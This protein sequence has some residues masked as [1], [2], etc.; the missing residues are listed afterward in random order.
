M[1]FSGM[2]SS[3]P[4]TP[5]RGG[6]HF[7]SCCSVTVLPADSKWQREGVDDEADRSLLRLHASCPFP[8][9]WSV[10]R[11]KV[12][13]VGRNCC[14]DAEPDSLLSKCAILVLIA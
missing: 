10:P 14:Y 12:S 1:T 3:R 5:V 7:V 13:F 6:E 2:A 11:G 4:G 9:Y 8:D